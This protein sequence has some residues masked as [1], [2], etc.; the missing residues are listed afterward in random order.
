MNDNDLEREL[1]SQRGPREDGYQPAALPMSL[2]EQPLPAAKPRRLWRAGLFVGVGAA[3]AVAVAVVAGIM[4]APGTGPGVG[5]GSESPSAEASPP[6]IGACGVLD[7]SLSA[8]PWG[9]A[10]GSRGTVVTVTLANGRY[11]C[12]LGGAVS[13]LI[14]DASG[15]LLVSGQRAS[16]GF[17]ALEP[18]TAYTVG[19]AWS[20]WCADA[21]ATPVTLALK[22]GGWPSA[23]EVPVPGALDSAPPCSGAG[24]RTTLSV[25]GL[26]AAP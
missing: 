15:T 13:A 7:V 17:V 11:P 4:S 24:Q 26:E 22:L 14:E 2:G 21:P 9:G 1:R 6:A 10:A 16:A 3:G 12:A 19:V 20:N 25:T 5:A 18:N 23:F 8:E